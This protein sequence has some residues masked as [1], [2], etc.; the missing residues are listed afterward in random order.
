MINSLSWLIAL[1][2]LAGTVLAQ[3]GDLGRLFFTP[4]ERASLDRERLRTGLPP[5]QAADADTPVADASMES[6]TLNGHIERSSGKGTL[7]LNGKVQQ[8]SPKRIAVTENTPG[9]IKVRHPDSSR[10]YSLKVGQTLTPGSG[11][12]RESYQRTPPNA[13]PDSPNAAKK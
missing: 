1:F 7:W 6:I 9:E 5:P 12:I 8:E 3:A 2:L 11:E 10:V 13:A 4:E